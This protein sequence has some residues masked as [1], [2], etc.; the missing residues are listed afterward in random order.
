VQADF[1]LRASKYA[2]VRYPGEDNYTDD[3]DTLATVTGNAMATYTHTLGAATRYRHILQEISAMGTDPYR[4]MLNSIKVLA[5]P[6]VFASGHLTSASV[7]DAVTELLEAAGVPAGAII[8]AGDT[9]TV[10]DYTTE[11]GMA[12]AIIADLADYTGCRVTVGRDSKVTIAADPY[13]SIAGIPAEAQNWT[14]LRV[15]AF[16][17]GWQSG[18][19]VGQVEL[20]WVAS[21]GNSRGTV[22]YPATKDF[23]GA[24]VRVG[25]YIYADAAAALV[26]A[27]K[28]YWQLRR[29]HG[30][31][32]E[33]AG[34][35]FANRAGEI[36]GALYTVDNDMQSIDRSYL[37]QSVDHAIE[38]GALT[39][40]FH[41]LQVSREDER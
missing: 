17:H 3:W 26:A 37:V 41:L 14:S 9:P 13:W 8:D 35:P 27:Q 21:D 30:A 29:P 7:A 28:R 16:E 34:A 18:R 23:F 25:P 32:V 38:N 40:V 1:V 4:P 12:W 39:S 20:D 24:V 22:R 31:L 5:D 15:T 36:H 19:T 33:A 6:S 11:P 2:T 10:D